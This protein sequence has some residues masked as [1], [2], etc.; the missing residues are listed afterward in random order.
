[1]IDFLNRHPLLSPADT[2][3]GTSANGATSLRDIV[4]VTIAPNKTAIISDPFAS[5]ISLDSP[6]NRVPGQDTGGR[7]LDL[8]VSDRRSLGCLSPVC[9]EASRSSGTHLGQNSLRQR[10][11][12]AVHPIETLL[13]VLQ[14]RRITQTDVIVGAKGYPRNGSHFLLFE[15][16][17]AKVRRFES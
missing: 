4:R 1:M 15:Q 13:D 16:S 5:G 10:P 9:A 8:G 12:E 3:L 14:A 7:R 11:D 6:E 17:S 2:G